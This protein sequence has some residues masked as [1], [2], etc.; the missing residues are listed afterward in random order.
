MGGCQSLCGGKDDKKI[1]EGLLRKESTSRDFAASSTEQRCI[2][3]SLVK[4]DVNY[5]YDCGGDFRS[6][7]T[8]TFRHHCRRCKNI[9]CG[10]CS[11]RQAKILQ[12]SVKEEVRVCNKCFEELPADNYYYEHLLPTLRKGDYFYKIANLGLSKKQTRVEISEDQTLLHYDFDSTEKD[13]RYNEK[14]NEN[15]ITVKN[16]AKVSNTSFVGFEIKVKNSRSHKFEA[17]S[18][19]IQKTWIEALTIASERANK[20]SLCERVDSERFLKAEAAKRRMGSASK[21]EKNKEFKS[22]VRKA[23]LVSRE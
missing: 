9:F 19:S 17:E 6:N 12:F 1:V 22:I 8:H 10:T 18:S 14:K 13:S 15:T 21:K 5:C 2:P 7:I 4:E 3:T 11:S 16:I 20:P 23:K